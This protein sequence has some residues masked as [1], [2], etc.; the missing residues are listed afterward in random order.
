MGA[1]SHS[2]RFASVTHWYSSFTGGRSEASQHE[3]TCCPMSSSFGSGKKIHVELS[4]VLW[5]SSK[6]ATALLLQDLCE[7]VLARS[8]GSLDFPEF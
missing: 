6:Q 3:A 7:W 8:Q 2:P 4:I 1:A 5:H